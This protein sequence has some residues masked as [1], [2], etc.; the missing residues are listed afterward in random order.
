MDEA[1]FLAGVKLT[2]IPDSQHI[3]IPAHCTVEQVAIQKLP[4]FPEDKFFTVNKDLWDRMDTA[5]Q[6]GLILHE[7]IYRRFLKLR[8]PGTTLSSSVA[9]RYLTGYAC[10]DR[11]AKMTLPEYFKLMERVQHYDSVWVERSFF[12]V[13]HPIY[14]H[15]NG[16]VSMGWLQSSYEVQSPLNNLCITNI[17]NAVTVS[18]YPSG[19]PEF[20]STRPLDGKPVEGK[21]LRFGE[22][23]VYMRGSVRD[24]FDFA[25]FD[26]GIP[27]GGFLSQSK[28]IKVGDV[29]VELAASPSIIFS[30][31]R[32]TYIFEKSRNV[33]MEDDVR[34]FSNGALQVGIL[35]RDVTLANTKGQKVLFRK[36]SK[37]TFNERG[38]V[39]SI[40]T[41]TQEQI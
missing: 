14:L 27:K 20:V 18:Q 15:P 34:F 24:G 8:K 17:P 38:Q 35:N 16:V 37:L 29:D 12:L 11:F 9:A 31:E 6:A 13:N 39:I 41:Q 7:T 10:S 40:K 5:N 3:A 25:F 2:D 28:E 33:V 4:A 32:K 1:K 30:L 21:F 26:G 23:C 19:L 22:S 36:G